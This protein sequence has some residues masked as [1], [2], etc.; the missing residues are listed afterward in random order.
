M[1]R[2]ARHAKII[3]ARACP[4]SASALFDSQAPTMTLRIGISARL[5]HNPP[6]GLG[7]PTKRLQFL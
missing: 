6:P 2:Q 7:L 1:R 4:I 5:L 3:A